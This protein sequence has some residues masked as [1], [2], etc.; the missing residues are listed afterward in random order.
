[1]DS[2]IYTGGCTIL[3][4]YIVIILYNMHNTYM[5][6]IPLRS[7]TSNPCIHTTFGLVT[8]MSALQRTTVQHGD[9]SYIFTFHL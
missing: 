7:C 5:E 1:M 6:S 3:I 9:S 2:T 8:Y 4:Y